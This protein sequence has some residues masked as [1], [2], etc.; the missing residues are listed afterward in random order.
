M[1]DSNIIYCIVEIMNNTMTKAFKQVKGALNRENET[2][3]KC[4]K[5]WLKRVCSDL[6]GTIWHGLA[7]EALD[8]VNV[9]LRAF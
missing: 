1:L 5:I 8:L 2:E 3:L 9:K 4:K 6:P 7:I